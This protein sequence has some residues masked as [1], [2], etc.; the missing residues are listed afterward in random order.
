MSQPWKDRP[1]RV[2]QPWKGRPRQVS[3]PWKRRSRMVS[4]RQMSPLQQLLR[5]WVGRSEQG[6]MPRLGQWR[7]RVSRLQTGLSLTVSPP[8]DLPWQVARLLRRG[9][10]TLGGGQ[11]A[12]FRQ[13]R[14]QS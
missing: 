5:L 12:P 3:Q 13:L 9:S 11:E 8:T 6:L 2:S 10:P 14:G 7:R 1:R 4:L